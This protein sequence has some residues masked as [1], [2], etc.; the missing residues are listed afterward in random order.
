MTRIFCTLLF[1]VA[2][3]SIFAQWQQANGPEGSK[4]YHLDRYNEE[5]WAASSAGLFISNDEAQNWTKAPFLPAECVVFDMILDSADI[6]LLVYAYDTLEDFSY[7]SDLFL[8]W[9][10]DGGQSWSRSQAPNVSINTFHPEIYKIDEYIFFNN[11]NYLLRSEDNG[12]SWPLVLSTFMTDMACNGKELIYSN[13]YASFISY[14]YGDTFELFDSISTQSEIFFEDSMVVL[15]GSNDSMYISLDLGASWNAVRSPALYGGRTLF[16]RGASGRLYYVSRSQTFHSNDNGYTWNPDTL[17]PPKYAYAEFRDLLELDNG[18]YAY[19]ENGVLVSS[20]NGSNWSNATN[21]MIG[22][23]GYVIRTLP[24]GDLIASTNVGYFRSPNGG[25]DWYRFN[26]GY[27]RPDLSSLIMLGDSVVFIDHGTVYISTD[28]FVTFDSVSVAPVTADLMRYRNGTFFIA[29]DSPY[30]SKDLVNWNQFDIDS[31]E[32]NDGVDDIALSRD[33]TLFVLSN[34]GR[35]YRSAD[36]A[37]S[38]TKVHELWA[39][40]ARPTRFYVMGSYLFAMDHDEWHISFDDGLTWERVALEN[41]PEQRDH[42]DI[43]IRSFVEVDGILFAV[44]PNFGIYK[45]SDLGESWEPFNDGL[46][47]LRTA[48]IHYSNERLYCGTYGNGIWRQGASIKTA[49]GLVFED[50]NGN[51]IRDTLEQPVPNVLIQARPF[52]TYAYSQF[53]GKFEISVNQFSDTVSVI[54]STPYCSFSPSYYVTSE[55]ISDLDFAM[56]CT[57]DINDLSIDIANMEH[58]RPGFD[59]TLVITVENVGTV[60]ASPSVTFYQSED[61]IYATSTPAPS[62]VDADSIV[63][64]LPELPPFGKATIFVNVVVDVYVAID[65]WLELNATVFPIT[66]DENPVDNYGELRSQVVG[67]FDPNDKQVFPKGEFTPD[68]LAQGDPLIY[69]IRFQNTGNYLAEHVRIVDTIS[70]LLDIATI[71]ILSSS[72]DMTHH[73]H[74]DNTVEFVFESIFLPDSFS[75]EPESHG[76]VK[77]SLKPK[78][79]I[80]ISDEIQNFADIYFDFNAPI[81]T[82]TV[83]NIFSYKSFVHHRR[84]AN[85]IVIFPNPAVDYCEFSM[86]SS[87]SGSGLL[88]VIGSDGKSILTQQ[89]NIEKGQLLFSSRQL[90]TGVYTIK[91]HF[92][93][94]C[95]FG[96]LVKH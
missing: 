2:S 6:F 12:L 57:P 1:S 55:S 31:L 73:I 38:W 14:D 49:A 53:D 85:D 46:S 4:I 42:S 29:T 90:A 60:S 32:S 67:A 34:H 66:A 26:L 79:T 48:C 15:E 93:G 8:Y 72:H 59:N 69:T 74:R 22:S 44:V 51:G 50:E 61:L 80:A 83:K 63:W 21:H 76:F 45:S 58:F 28:N 56:Q 86:P 33:S 36:G 13:Y 20:D 7:T 62:F 23:S 75:N 41:I 92:E 37:Q 82:N 84:V 81:R 94:E 96:R 47:T 91:V 24:N 68:M 3:F 27:I 18:E 39:P 87:V 30:Y 78:S 88:D 77:F 64:D 5:I 35:V 71:D 65:D 95:F 11:G 89:V 25:D 70:Q 17:V 43:D 9:S 40:G 19:G 10:D 16:K 52:N 54:S